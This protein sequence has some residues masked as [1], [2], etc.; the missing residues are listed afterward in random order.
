[1]GIGNWHSQIASLTRDIDEFQSEQR[2]VE[3]Q[4][5]K[6]EVAKDKLRKITSENNETNCLS[7]ELFNV[8]GWMGTHYN[9]HEDETIINYVD[10]YRL[11]FSQIEEGKDDI[12]RKIRE[13]E[14]KS[15]DIS[16]KIDNAQRSINSLRREIKRNQQQE[17]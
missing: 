6:L 11:Y 14:S 2:M 13:L 5:K 3:G 1:M 9:N 7:Q 8:E 17:K 4:I 15:E 16:R 12:D 10:G